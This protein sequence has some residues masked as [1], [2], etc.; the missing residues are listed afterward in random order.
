MS[1]AV[2]VSDLFADAFDAGDI[3]QSTLN[4]LN[5]HD[6]GVDI[7]AAIGVS[8]DD[9]GSGE[10][11][12]M[13]LI[14]DD[15]SSIDYYSN[16]QVVRDGYNMVL[17]ALKSAKL[18][19]NILVHCVSLNAGVLHPFC[20]LDDAPKLDATNYMPNGGTPLYGTCLT[21]LATV[22][23]KW[24]DYTNNGVDARTITVIITDGASTDSGVAKVATMVHD[25]VS[26]ENHIIAGMGIDD[27]GTDF[28]EVFKEMGIL[29]KWVLTPG[30]TEKEVRQAFGTIS[31]SAVRASQSALS[32]SQTNAGGFGG[33]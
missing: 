25:M 12:F 26:M 6:L 23:A 17:D 16:A 3:S 27:G 10:S 31:S 20:K 14:L 24:Q 7:N 15:S 11:V 33:N 4:V 5:A 22:L 2:N 32:F 8:V 1:E 18:R 13:T 29:E 30:N 19:D 28:T 9:L 21:T